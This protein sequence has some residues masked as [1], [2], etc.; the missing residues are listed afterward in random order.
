MICINGV[1]E[2]FDIEGVMYQCLGVNEAGLCL[3][4]LSFSKRMDFGR[5]FFMVMSY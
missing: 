3:E 1:S 5:V 2:C 4:V